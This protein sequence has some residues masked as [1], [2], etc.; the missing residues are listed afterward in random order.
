MRTASP[1]SRF[2]CLLPSMGETWKP[3]RGDLPPTLLPAGGQKNFQ[4]LAVNG[5]GR[6]VAEA[7]KQPMELLEQASLNQPVS[8]T[9]HP[10]PSDRLL[11][12]ACQTRSRAVTSQEWFGESHAF[13][14]ERAWSRGVVGIFCRQ[15]PLYR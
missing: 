11:P 14:G 6:R 13:S 10:G 3:I 4:W 15:Q 8:T 7:Q 1:Q 2:F 5:S 12:C 9:P